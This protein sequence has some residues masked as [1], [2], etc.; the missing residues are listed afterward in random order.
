MHFL[1]A[2]PSNLD[3]VC[4][5]AI[6]Y[7]TQTEQ[8]K[9]DGKAYVQSNLLTLHDLFTASLSADRLLFSEGTSTFVAGY[10]AEIVAED[11]SKLLQFGGP[12][13]ETKKA[14]QC[15]KDRGE[16]KAPD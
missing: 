15:S 6:S 10:P 1:S 5:R 7:L 16:V 12:T 14:R 3:D 2:T 13:T 8:P 4:N 11:R 9:S